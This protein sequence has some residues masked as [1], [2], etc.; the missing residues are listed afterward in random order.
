[1]AEVAVECAGCGWRPVPKGAP[2]PACPRRAELPA[3]DHVLRL[4]PALGGR[5]LPGTGDINPFIRFRRL[6][7]IYQLALARGVDDEQYVDAVRWLDQRVE[8]VWGHG[9]EVTPYRRS[10][11]LGV[12]YKDETGNVAGS[13]KARHLMGIAIWLELIDHPREAPL[14][15][16]SCGNA[17][18]AAAVVARAAE[19]PLEVFIP[20][21]AGADVRARLTE[22][23]ATT[24]ICSRDT[25]AA[26]D[27]CVRGF[28]QAVASGAL[29]FAC[30]GHANGF[31][32]DGGKTLG[33]ELAAQHRD[34]AWP[35]LTDVF[36]QIGGGALA[37]A[38][39]QA[40]ED[41]RELGAIDATPRLRPV[42]TAGCHPMIR[43][44]SAI[45]GDPD[46]A[47][48]L[49]RGR[50]RRDE[51]MSPWPMGDNDTPVSAARGIL[52]DETYDWWQIARG[53]IASG[54]GGVIVSEDQLAA[55]RAA[56]IDAGVNA[57]TTGASGYAGARA[58]G[59]G[60]HT[61]VLFTGVGVGGSAGRGS[62]PPAEP[63]NKRGEA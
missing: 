32:I 17:A 27:P 61:A 23:G 25:A 21:T 3:A 12:Y 37:S 55:A 53:A 14:A 45:A 46:P 2:P 47:A 52:D 56:A 63:G 9:F 51:L 58:A 10:D 44:L 38:V 7:A 60:E 39:W 49:E 54:G 24:R 16:A 29:P 1:M 11:E 26:G 59:A 13:H 42:Q 5:E 8:S 41:A 62:K 20:P 57:S 4:R 30:Q 15:I 50:T 18:L 43:A 22:L 40:L 19:R 33:Y 6:S 31:T 48:A 28:E 34:G 35:P 36:I